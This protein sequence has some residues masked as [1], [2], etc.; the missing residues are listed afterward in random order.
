MVS[1]GPGPLPTLSSFS[2]VELLVVD[3]IFSVVVGLDFVEMCAGGV[4]GVDEA[5][6]G[7]VDVAADS[8]CG[9]G[10]NLRFDS[11]SDADA[12][13]SDECAK[14]DPF[15]GLSAHSNSEIS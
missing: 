2:F 9:L 11:D 13:T 1:C 4:P 8:G 14:S 3:V 10:L 12:G 15:S 7:S 6:T 5:F